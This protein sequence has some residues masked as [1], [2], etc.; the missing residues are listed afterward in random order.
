MKKVRLTKIEIAMLKQLARGNTFLSKYFDFSEQEI[1][2]SHMYLARQQYIDIGSD[3]D[4]LTL[5]GIKFLK[6][7]RNLHILYTI[8]IA[9]A[10]LAI[11]FF[12]ELKALFNF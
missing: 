6:A 2:D 9:L 5:K 11:L 10:V 1:K 8:L 4:Y 7:R 3:G 12:P